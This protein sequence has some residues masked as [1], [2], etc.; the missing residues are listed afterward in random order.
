MIIYFLY[1][2]ILALYFVFLTL[3]SLYLLNVIISKSHFP[4][5]SQVTVSSFHSAM[6]TSCFPL[7]FIIFNHKFIFSRVGFPCESLKAWAVEVVLSLP[8]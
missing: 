7:W 6:P 8:L 1:C 2:S 4:P 5:L 3:L